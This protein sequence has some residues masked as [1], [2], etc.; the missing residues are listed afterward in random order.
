MDTAFES[1]FALPHMLTIVVATI[2]HPGSM[3]AVLRGLHAQYLLRA[4]SRMSPGRCWC[5]AAEGA[6]AAAGVAG[7]DSTLKMHTWHR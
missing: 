2:S 6:H 1:S 4:S 7:G 3:L 5:L